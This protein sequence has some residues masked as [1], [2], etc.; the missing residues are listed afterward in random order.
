MNI[1]HLGLALFGTSLFTTAFTAVAQTPNKSLDNPQQLSSE[2]RSQ[3]RTRLQTQRLPDLD[4]QQGLQQRPFIPNQGNP[5]FPQ[6]FAPWL[7][8]RNSDPE[9]NQ[10]RSQSRSLRHGMMR[11][12]QFAHRMDERMSSGQSS[13]NASRLDRVKSRLNLTSAQEGAW[14]KY[15]QA[16]QDNVAAIKKSRESVD[17]DAVR[18]MNPAERFL[19]I[20]KQRQQIQKPLD[21]IQ[22]AT[23]EL[24]KALDDSQKIRAQHMLPTLENLLSIASPS[25]D[26]LQDRGNQ[27]N[28]PR[29]YRR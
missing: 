1:K 18:K 10:F 13:F 7:Q 9:W 5:Q 21:A 15:T 28:E 27:R 22:S 23:D 12:Q 26:R 2:P 19:F 6:R 16:I 29:N 24:T 17:D 4:P 25:T 8:D 14:N 11:Q 20:T 3:L